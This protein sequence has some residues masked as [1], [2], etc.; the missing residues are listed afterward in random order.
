MRR[1]GPIHSIARICGR[2]RT[3]SGC[4]AGM[5]LLQFKLHV[6]Y[7]RI[8]FQQYVAV[9]NAWQARRVPN[10]LG[11][12]LA[13]LVGC[14]ALTAYNSVAKVMDSLQLGIKIRGAKLRRNSNDA[15][16]LHYTI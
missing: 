2:I 10:G 6:N 14:S 15:T 8:S 12:D 3:V 1:A 16:I 9:P 5:K 7:L 11:K 4:L 13:A